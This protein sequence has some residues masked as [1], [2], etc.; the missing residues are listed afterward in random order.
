MDLK[1]ILD[2]IDVMQER[3]HIRSDRDLSLRAGL[4]SDAIRNIRRRVAA[5]E[6]G[7]GGVRPATIDA[8]A[9]SLGVSPAWLSTGEEDIGTESGRPSIVRTVSPQVLADLRRVKCY[10][11]EAAAGGGAVITIEEPLW[12]IGFSPQMIR[13]F[14]SAPN[15]ALALIRVRGDS[16][17]PTLMDGDWMMVDTTKRN[18]NYDGLFILRY[19][20]VLRVKRVDKNPATGRYLVKSDNP[21]YDAFEVEAFDLHVIG[22]VVWIGRRV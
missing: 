4:S 14:T 9:L 6:E 8:L 18:I 22:R 19:D 2:R 16:M 5:G 21:A 11:I 7:D 15:D 10:D 17:V 12:E 20:D 3:L 13:A 1:G